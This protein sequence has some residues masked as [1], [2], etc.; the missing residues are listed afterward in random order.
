MMYQTQPQLGAASWA[1]L[2]T[3][4]M[5]NLPSSRSFKTVLPWLPLPPMDAPPAPAKADAA[6]QVFDLSSWLRQNQT[7][8]LTAAAVL[9][10]LA[11]ISA[12]KGRR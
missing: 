2:E 11:L 12:L 10:G 1:D 6:P 8:V 4:V 7:A 9:G 5:Q 3:Y